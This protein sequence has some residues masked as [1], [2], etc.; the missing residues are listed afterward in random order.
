MYMSEVRVTKGNIG[1]NRNTGNNIKHL[2]GYF[3]LTENKVSV[4]TNVM[5]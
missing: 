4:C 2:Q 1:A 3:Y 5:R